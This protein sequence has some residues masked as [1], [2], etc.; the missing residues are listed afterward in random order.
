MTLN[1]AARSATGGP[2]GTKGVSGV[3][4]IVEKLVQKKKNWRYYGVSDEAD[5]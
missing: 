5:V 4:C 2:G 1:D 3:T